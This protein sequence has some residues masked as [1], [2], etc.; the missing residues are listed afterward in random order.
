MYSKTLTFFSK[1]GRGTWSKKGH[2]HPYV[3]IEQPL[4][5]FKG[6]LQKIKDFLKEI[7]SLMEIRYSR[8]Q[9]TK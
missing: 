2:N 8:V 3:I 6:L 1:V 4:T 9:N 5:I 7:I